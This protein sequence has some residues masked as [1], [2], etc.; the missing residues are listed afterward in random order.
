MVLIAVTYPPNNVGAQNIYLSRH[1]YTIALAAESKFLMP[2]IV[3]A[4]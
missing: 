2:D 3:V 1:S 4:I